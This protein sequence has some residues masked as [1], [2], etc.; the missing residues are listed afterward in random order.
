MEKKKY[1]KMPEEIQESYTREI[2]EGRLR[3]TKA[4]KEL[5]VARGTIYKWID[6][7][8]EE[9]AKTGKIRIKSKKEIETEKELKRLKEENELLKKAIAYFSR[10]HKQNMR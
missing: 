1:V 8:K 2:I 4:M 10:S 6:K 3:I 7:Y 9:D 5:G